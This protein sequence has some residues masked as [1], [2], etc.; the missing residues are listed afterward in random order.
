MSNTDFLLLMLA[1]GAVTYLP[2]MLPLVMLSRRTLP[3]WFAEWLEL[4]PAAI[5]SALIT[6]TLFAHSAP[7]LFT[8]GKVELLAA[9]PTLLCAFKTRSLA[10]TVIVGMLCYWGLNLVM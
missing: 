9:L 10:G 1:M 3:G 6:P 7:R 8:L 4:V 2:R 5:L